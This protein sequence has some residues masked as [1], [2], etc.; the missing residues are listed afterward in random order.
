MLCQYC[1]KHPVTTHVK[2]IV[3][4]ELTEYLL[5]AGCAQKLGYGSLLTGLGLSFGGALGEIFGS[6]DDGFETVR[7]A[8]CGA[9]FEEIAR[10]GK[11]GCAEC[12]RTFR[13]R[14]MPLIQQIHGGTRH[15][16]KVPGEGLSLARPDGQLAVMRSRLREAIGSEDFEQAAV[17]RDSIRRLEAGEEHHGE[18]GEHRE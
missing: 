17:L 9:S 14:L 2:T 16:G 12:Y 5:C 18:S 8:C 3:N 6:R 11:V 4:G 15:R 7:C 10:G 13:D 1:G